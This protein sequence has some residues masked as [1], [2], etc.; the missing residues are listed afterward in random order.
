MRS[1]FAKCLNVGE[2]RGS[3]EMSSSERFSQ[4]CAFRESGFHTLNPLSPLNSDAYSENVL[5][6]LVLLWTV[7]GSFYPN[8][9]LVLVA[10]RSAGRLAQGILSEVE[11]VVVVW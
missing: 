9:V 8:C 5:E 7:R 3:F 11:G 4:P 2:G 1:T 6:A 10:V